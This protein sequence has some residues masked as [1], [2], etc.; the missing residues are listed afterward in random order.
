MG[1]AN[2]FSF[3]LK[4]SRLN[5]RLANKKVPPGNRGKNGQTTVAP[6]KAWR[7]S[8]AKPLR[9]LTA[10]ENNRSR[11]KVA[12]LNYTFPATQSQCFR[13]CS[14]FR[15]FFALSLASRE[16]FVL[17]N[18]LGLEY[19]AMIRPTFSQDSVDWCDGMDGL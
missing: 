19:P 8:L 16:Q 14:G 6:I 7:G 15:F 11:G 2:G 17:P 4:I 1:K 13:C 18:H 10:K 9:H 3:P 12:T 5:V